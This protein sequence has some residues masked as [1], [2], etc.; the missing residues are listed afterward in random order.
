MTPRSISYRR[1]GLVIFI[2][3]AFLGSCAMPSPPKRT[4]LVYGISIYDTAKAEGSYPNLTL[5]DEDATSMAAMLTTEGWSV[6]AGIADSNIDRNNQDA[7]RTAIENGIAGLA[8]TD[9]L[10]LFYY[11]G[12]GSMVNGE[13]V[14]IPYGTVTEPTQW[15]TATELRARF[16]A[17]GL[18]HVIIMLDSCYSGG[19]VSSGATTDAIPPIYD[20]LELDRRIQYRLFVDAIGDAI[21]AYMAYA[22]DPEFIV[23]SAAGAG[24]LS[25][26]SSSFGHGIFTYYALKA[27]SDARADVDSDGFVTTTELY[28]YIAANIQANWNKYYYNDP[29]NESGV[30]PQYSDY[31]PHLS[32]TA[33]EYALWS[34]R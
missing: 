2:C 29:I 24:E 1:K 33:Y 27:F 4:A 23:L 21:A 26:E 19:F 13:S 22:D 5:T 25:W 18:H 31:M 8:G 20:S 17:A 12:H 11:S 7:S 30:T 6:T 16:R 3:A 10:V 34:T 9:G 14:I 28:A 15:I 32:G